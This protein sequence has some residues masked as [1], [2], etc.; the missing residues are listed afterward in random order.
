[1]S[2]VQ[3]QSRLRLHMHLPQD[4]ATAVLRR[5]CAFGCAPISR[6]DTAMDELDAMSK[7]KLRLEVQKLRHHNSGWFCCDPSSLLQAVPLK[8][9]VHSCAP[10]VLQSWNLRTESFVTTPTVFSLSC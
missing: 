9:P 6:A 1:M 7:T 2:Q 5:S 3:T 8:P 10:H 4:S